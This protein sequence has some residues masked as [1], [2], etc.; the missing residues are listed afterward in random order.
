MD[1]T[2]LPLA[3]TALLL[4]TFRPAAG[5]SAPTKGGE[6]PPA[7]A[8][9]E[10]IPAADAFTPTG[11]LRPDLF[12]PG[13]AAMLAR[14][15]KA[16]STGCEQ[17][18][19]QNLFDESLGRAPLD[20]LV[21]ASLLILRG[22]LSHAEA[23]FYL[24]LPGTLFTLVPSEVLKIDPRVAARSTFFIF[25]PEATIQTPIGFIC[26]KAR[27]TAR[28]K[29]PA[30]V[31]GDEVLLFVSLPPINTARDIL[32]VDTETQ[33]VVNR[34]G[35]ILAPA[36]L[37]RSPDGATKPFASLDDLASEIKMN[38]HLLDSPKGQLR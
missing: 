17:F 30:P 20:P 36:A 11:E 27:G 33:V 25:I 38:L 26:S 24:D 32:R 6:A 21:S 19:V 29:N 1:R 2:R 31:V 34:D 8:S 4:V 22:R 23:G 3:L 18:I 9:W 14:H 37:E 16:N 13:Y 35:R 5:Q 7:S 15:L 10:W 12:V 28:G